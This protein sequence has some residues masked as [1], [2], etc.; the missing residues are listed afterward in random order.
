MTRFLLDINGF[1]MSILA[2]DIV[3]SVIMT[4]LSAYSIVFTL[5]RIPALSLLER[6]VDGILNDV[7]LLVY[8]CE[9]DR[10]EESRRVIGRCGHRLDRVGIYLAE[11]GLPK[12]TNRISK[13]AEHL[14]AHPKTFAARTDQ[15]DCQA[16]SLLAAKRACPSSP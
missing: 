14:P 1:Y 2:S 12:A 9:R 7:K 13:G 6:L 8:P 4:Y 11:L 5:P 3:V 16:C 10:H 15:G